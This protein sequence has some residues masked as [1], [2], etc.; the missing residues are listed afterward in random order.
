MSNVMQSSAG[1]LLFPEFFTKPYTRT[2]VVRSPWWKRPWRTVRG[3]QTRWVV[4]WN[5]PPIQST[6]NPMK[7]ALPSFRASRGV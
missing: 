1:G 3:R 2:I 7:D 4:Q 6:R 5:E